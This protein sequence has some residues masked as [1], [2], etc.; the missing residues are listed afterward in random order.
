MAGLYLGGL[1]GGR[2]WGRILSYPPGG[3]EAIM[4]LPLIMRFMLYLIVGSSGHYWVHRFL[5][6]PH[7]W[8]M[9]RWHHYP[10]YMY[11]LAGGRGSVLQ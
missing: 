10:T 3:P 1:P 6:T 8:R 2:I 5:H 4:A 11:W 9:H 7:L